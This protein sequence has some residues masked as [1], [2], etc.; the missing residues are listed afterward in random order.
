VVPEVGGSKPLTHPFYLLHFQWISLDWFSCVTDT[1][2]MSPSTL[3]LNSSTAALFL[4]SFECMYLWV[5]VMLWCP[6]SSLRVSMST[7][8][9]TK[10][11][12]NV[13][14]LCRIRHNRHSF[15]THL[16]EAGTNLYHI[17]LLL[18]HRSLNTTAIYLHV[19]RKELVRIVSPLD[20]TPSNNS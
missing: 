17:Q 12:A 9:A 10:R 16:L 19:S 15:A 7:P 5:S 3:L 13:W 20:F 1:S 18:G 14:R 6:S 8:F 4:S 11:L 2:Q